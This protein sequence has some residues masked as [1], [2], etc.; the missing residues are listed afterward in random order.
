[1]DGDRLFVGEGDLA[2]ARELAET[3]DRAELLL[4]PGTQHL[5]ADSSLPGYDAEASALL[6]QRVLG[7]LDA[8]AR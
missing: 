1:M 3:A 4:Y 5:F 8:V 7:F 6:A 2:A